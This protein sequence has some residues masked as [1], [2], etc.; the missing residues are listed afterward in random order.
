MESQGDE[1]PGGGGLGR[2]GVCFSKSHVVF[3]LSFER[4]GNYSALKV[5]GLYFASVLGG[6]AAECPSLLTSLLVTHFLNVKAS[7]ASPHANPFKSQH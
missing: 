1:S 7:S 5:T 6:D 2:K 3:F 4:G